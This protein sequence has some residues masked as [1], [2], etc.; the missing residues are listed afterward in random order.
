MVVLTERMRQMTQAV[1]WQVLQGRRAVRG[2]SSEAQVKQGPRSAPLPSSGHQNAP[3]G[4]SWPQGTDAAIPSTAFRVQA[5]T[6]A[7]CVWYWEALALDTS[8]V[9]RIVPWRVS[10]R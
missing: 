10:R 4:L 2:T 6:N 8:V 3:H 5:R 7:R 9:R 1:R